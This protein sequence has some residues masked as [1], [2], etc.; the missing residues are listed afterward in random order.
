MEISMR[1][2]C[3]L[4]LALLVACADSDDDHGHDHDDH[5]HGCEHDSYQCDGDILQECDDGVWADVEDC[6]ANGQICH[7]EGE[8]CMDE[9]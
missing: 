9:M 8:H 7:A 5:T 4:A 1:S 2:I 3:L 6:A